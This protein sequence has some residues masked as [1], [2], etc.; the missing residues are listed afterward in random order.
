ME[1]CRDLSFT[2]KVPATSA[3][4]GPGFDS[5]GLA[6][7]MYSTLKVEILDVPGIT[8]E[9]R[10][11][12]QFPSDDSNL[13]VRS[14]LH[15]FASRG[16]TAP[17]L[18]LVSDFDFPPGRGLGSSAAAISS[19]VLAAQRIMSHASYPHDSAESFILA[20]DIEGHPDNI[21]AALFGGLTIAWLRGSGEKTVSPSY[22]HD[23][24]A[25]Q[26]TEPAYKKLVPH[27]AIRPVIFVPVN[28]QMSTVVA[29][30]LQ[31]FSVPYT[32]A[33]FNL[34]R[35]ALLVAALTQSPDVLLEATEDRLHQNYRADAMP[36]TFSLIEHLRH[37]KLAAVVS[38]AG[39]S[40]LVLTV[41]PAERL[42]AIDVVT[43]HAKG[44]W[45]HFMPAID[46]EGARIFDG[47]DPLGPFS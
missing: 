20:T 7:G 18:R 13:I 10:G 15:V 33:V 29:R 40:I 2:V 22:R 17:G 34:S 5:L 41:D 30:G 1:G 3:N 6:L 19:A 23:S 21:A 8:I 24:S 42:K 46:F 14:L 45:E 31:P 26:G 16:F 35:S 39:P 12:S 28:Q 47:H 11:S 32:D 4:L 43:S 38:G 27:R 37:A 25:R 36:E 44:Q 9:T